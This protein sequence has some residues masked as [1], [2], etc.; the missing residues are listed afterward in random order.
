MDTLEYIE[1][2]KES[3]K[4]LIRFSGGYDTC[5]SVLLKWPDMVTSLLTKDENLNKDIH[6]LVCHPIYILVMALMERLKI[7]KIDL[8]NYS[9][10]IESVYK[11]ED[12]IKTKENLIKIAD[13]L[14]DKLGKNGLKLPHCREEEE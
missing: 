4:I 7:Q 3:L 11:S 2:A 13:F 9:K 8:G 10:K 1:E 12:I 6:Y 5:I 14:I